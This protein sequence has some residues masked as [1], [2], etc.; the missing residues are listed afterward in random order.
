LT[1]AETSSSLLSFFSIRTAHAAQLIPSI[2][3]SISRVAG[4]AAS[5]RSGESISRTRL[6]GVRQAIGPANGW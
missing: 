1:D 3:S 6:P 2:E 4:G 5:A